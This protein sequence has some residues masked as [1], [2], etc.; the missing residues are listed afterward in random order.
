MRGSSHLRHSRRQLRHTRAC[1]GHLAV[2][3]TKPAHSHQLHHRRAL[4]PP[5]FLPPF[6]SYPCLPRVSRRHLHQ[7]LAHSPQLHHR[8]ALPPPSFLPPFPSYPCL[9]R[10]SRRHL[11]QALAHSPQLHHRRALPP[12]SF[13]PPTPSYPCLPRVSRRQHH[14][15]LAH[16][17]NPTIAAPTSPVIPAPYSVIPVLATGISPPPPPRPRTV[18]TPAHSPP[19][20]SLGEEATR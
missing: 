5:S 3:T 12:P 2:N 15:A 9:P 13:P 14:Q 8:R 20:F 18:T 11:H 17:P 7:A 6:P 4:P 16:S 10:V 1:H 19:P